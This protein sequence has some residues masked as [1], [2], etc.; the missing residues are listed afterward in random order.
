MPDD[1]REQLYI[2]REDDTVRLGSLFITLSELCGI[3]KKGVVL[4]MDEVDDTSDNKVFQ[5]FPLNAKFET[6][7]IMKQTVHGTL[8]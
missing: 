1:I 7:T 8:L 5:S 4:I 2:Q 6:R 3:S